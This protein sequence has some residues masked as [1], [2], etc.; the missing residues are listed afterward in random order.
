MNVSD[1]LDKVRISDARFW[2]AGTA[3][4]GIPMA[5]YPGNDGGQGFNQAEG[6]AHV[7]NLL[8]ENTAILEGGHAASFIIGVTNMLH[9]NTIFRNNW[10]LYVYGQSDAATWS[11]GHTNTGKG[12]RACEWDQVVNCVTR[13]CV[14]IGTREAA[15]TSNTQIIKYNAK[16]GSSSQCIW[17]DH[18][19]G[20]SAMALLSTTVNDGS[21]DDLYFDHIT[22]YAIDGGA[23][24]RK[25]NGGSEA[26]TVHIKNCIFQDVAQRSGGSN[27]QFVIY[28][29]FDSSKSGAR[30]DWTQLLFVDG[31]LSFA[32]YQIRIGDVVAGVISTF[33]LSEAHGLY[34]ANFGEKIV[35]ANPNFVSTSIPTS[36]DPATSI[37][38]AWV[39][40]SP[41]SA[42][43]TTV[44]VHLT[45]LTS[46]PVAN[47]TFSV[48]DAGWFRSAM[49]WGHLTGDVIYIEGVGSRIITDVTG[50]TITVSQ[51]V[52][53]ALGSRIWRGTTSSPRV[54]A[55]L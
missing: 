27:N 40:F 13:R 18:Q 6:G 17:L 32:D 19:A 33:R 22:F 44:A 37:A 50:N 34:P 55:V 15:D 24:N 52:T 14:S 12:N 43:A 54:G 4:N 3:N 25:D 38:Q 36:E 26:G 39:N 10:A 30:G 16:I 23:F 41:Q 11:S 29:L 48:V 53:A 35:I 20:G 5:P 47:N 42:Q 8:V 31:I 21:H 1:G 46:A 9:Y 28:F 45:T 2:L 7:T 49:G 51:V